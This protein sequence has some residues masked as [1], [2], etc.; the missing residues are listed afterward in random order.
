MYHSKEVTK[1]DLYKAFNSLNWDFLNYLLF[2]LGFPMRMLQWIHA[3]IT[4]PYFSVSLIGSLV[5]YF[6]G[7]RRVWQGDPLSPYLFVLAMDYLSALLDSVVI[8]GSI[9]YHPRCR[10]LQLTHLY[11]ANDLLIFMDGLA[12]LYE[13]LFKF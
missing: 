11:F 8:R 3:C 1:I 9:S 4:T 12:N 2:A 6:P 10:G 7:A 5:R 13:V